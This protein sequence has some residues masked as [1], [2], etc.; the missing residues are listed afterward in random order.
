M[1]AFEFKGHT[2]DEKFIEIET[3][4]NRLLIP[5]PMPMFKNTAL[6]MFSSYAD[7]LSFEGNIFK[8][9]FCTGQVKKLLLNFK[10][11]EEGET[12]FIFSLTRKNK[13]E[14]IEHTFKTTEIIEHVN[15][16]TEDGDLI[17]VACSGSIDQIYQIYCGIIFEPFMR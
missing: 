7:N 6:T 3:I 9:I 8:G 17:N 15:F 4:I 2:S 14:S 11:K 5:T 16:T 10:R 1:R 12:K 13:I